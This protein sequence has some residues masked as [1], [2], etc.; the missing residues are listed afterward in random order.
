MVLFIINFFFFFEF[1]NFHCYHYKSKLE[2][3]TLK[4]LL[5][6]VALP[7]SASFR[8][9][10]VAADEAH[11]NQFFSF[12]KLLFFLKKNLNFCLFR[13]NEYEKV[14]DSRTRVPFMLFLE[15]IGPLECIDVDTEIDDADAEVAQLNAG[16]L[17]RVDDSLNQSTKKI[18]I[19]F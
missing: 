8:I 9:V 16:L 14:L 18:G 5:R 2:T 10:R 11:V 17:Q 6:C 1:K 15:T 7:T 4:E 19:L 3:L 13:L 12:R